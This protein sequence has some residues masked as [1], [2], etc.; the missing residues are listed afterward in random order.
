VKQSTIY[1]LYMFITLYTF[2]KFH[3][4]TAVVINAVVIK[5][6]DQMMFL[7]RFNTLA[8]IRFTWWEKLFSRFQVVDFWVPKLNKGE[9]RSHSKI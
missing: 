3:S 7:T 6:V 2:V 4:Q 9:I 1:T 8:H 5:S